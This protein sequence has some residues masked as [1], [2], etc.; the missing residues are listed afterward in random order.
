MATVLTCSYLPVGDCGELTPRALLVPTEDNCLPPCF[1]DRG[2]SA[3]DNHITILI[4]DQYR[5][6]AAELS[7]GGPGGHPNKTP[8]QPL[9]RQRPPGEEGPR[10]EPPAPGRVVAAGRLH[11]DGA[12]PAK[13]K[14]RRFSIRSRP[15]R[16][17]NPRILC[18]I[19]TP[20]SPSSTKSRGNVL[21]QHASVPEKNGKAEKWPLSRRKSAQE[22]RPSA[23][24]LG[25]K[26]KKRQ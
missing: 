17:Q 25:K 1:C 15:H 7:S 18:P 23:P 2:T 13:H 24:S 20:P 9:R 12:V 3:E 14:T 6:P 4:S 11:G 21:L 5:N 19:D 8:I 22:P 10:T 26:G 16:A